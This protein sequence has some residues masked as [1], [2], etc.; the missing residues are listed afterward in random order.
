MLSRVFAVLVLLQAAVAFHF[1]QRPQIGGTR[2]QS[3]VFSLST[4]TVSEAPIEPKPCYYKRIDGSW[5]P[6]K[7]L[8]DLF[9]GERLFATRLAECDLIDGVTGPKAFVECGVGR[10]TDRKGQKWK[11]VNGMVRLGKKTGRK[12][13]MKESVVRK[14]LAKMPSDELFKVY[15]SKV[16]L[17]HGSLEGEMIFIPNTVPE[18]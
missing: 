13:R 7:Q 18:F 2:A 14:K 4:T 17:E 11:I 9:I 1:H 6:R 16:N 15:V 12:D 3:K 10:T 8:K 5:R